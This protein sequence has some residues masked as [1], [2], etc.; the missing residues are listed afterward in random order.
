MNANE[1]ALRAREW[2]VKAEHDLATARQALRIEDDRPCDTIAYLAQ[3]CA[4]KYLKALLVSHGTD[5]PRTH[6]LT[7]LATM[8]RE[9]AGLAINTSDVKVINRYAVEAR[10][11]GDW[12]PVLD[13]DAA[14]AV[15]AALKVREAVRAILPEASMRR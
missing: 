1:L 11:P 6:D 15:D 12:E 8:A 9:D 4:E 7:V 3:Q 13:D 5:L 10:Y 2:V 14:E